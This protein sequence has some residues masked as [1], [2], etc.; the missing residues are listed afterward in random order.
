MID[1]KPEDA[2]KLDI[3]KLDKIYPGEN[4]LTEDGLYRYLYWLGEQH[5]DQNGLQTLSRVKIHTG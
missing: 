1:M 3:V 5:R 2:I 4:I